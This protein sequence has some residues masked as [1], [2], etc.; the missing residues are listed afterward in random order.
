MSDGRAMT[1]EWFSAAELAGLP[2]MPGTERAIQ[3]AAKKSQWRAQKRAGRGGGNEYHAS[4]LP[5]A[6][7]RY[8]LRQAV[9]A[10]PA[11]AAA[12]APVV[13][14]LPSVDE[15]AGW[16]REVMMARLAV[17][18]LVE[19]F[20]R[21]GSL[22]TRQ[23]ILELL[24][25]AQDGALPAE[26]MQTLHAANA[27]QGK[28]QRRLADRSTIYRWMEARA[29]GAAALAPKAPPPEPVP[30]WM[31]PL[32]RLYQVT[33]RNSG[34]AACLREWPKHYPDIDPPELRTAQRHMAALPR[35]V[36]EW[37]RRGRNAL[38]SVQ[39]F[40]RRS[41][42]GLWPMDVVTVD[43]HLFKAYVK[44]P[45]DR[46]LKI[47]PEITT[48][49]DVATRRIVG[50]SCWLAESQVAIWAA[51][52]DMVL[53]AECG[54]PAIHY[55]DN[56]AYRGDIH[57][58]VMERIGSFMSFSQPYRAQS[59]GMIERLNSSVWVPLAQ[60]F[61]TYVNDDADAEHTKKAL[62]IANKTGDNLPEWVDFLGIVRRAIDEYNDR[63]HSSLPGRM[64][65]NQAWAKAVA[66]GWQPTLL[67][68]DGLFDILMQMTRTTTRGEISLPWGR[69]FHD[70]LRAYHGQRVAVC[71]HPTDGSRVG[72]M[73]SNERLICVAERDGNVRPYMSDSMVNHGRL[74]REG[75]AIKRKERDIANY[76]IEAD[77]A[78][79]LPAAEVVALRPQIAAPLEREDIERLDYDPERDVCFNSYMRDTMKHAFA[80][81]LDMPQEVEQ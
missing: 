20:A 57:R 19:E 66:E 32:L 21:R 10:V 27:R 6:T 35:E 13:V 30:S 42:D 44:N 33:L 70:E 62:T 37:G 60:T 7:R 31:A 73:D 81:S 16:Q 67:E 50:F 64:S 25:A 24:E 71:I 48:Y 9:A 3:I 78:R 38:R 29:K 22:S 15:L 12:P 1:K 72:V 34:V 74:V 26:Q 2:G 51:L 54:V 52:R 36:R 40:V 11:P 69:Y 61:A 8:L 47:R 53:N 68:G 58:S 79:S 65:P 23:A 49:L 14:E 76:R 63:A 39:P 4:N 18:S 45:M 28:H 41:T 59:R 80:D 17:C 77:S 46:R 56:G 43:G 55:S 5:E 75:A